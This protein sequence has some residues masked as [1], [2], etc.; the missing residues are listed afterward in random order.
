M[1][2]TS[3]VVGLAGTAVMTALVMGA[4]ARSAVPPNEAARLKSDLTPLGAERAGNQAG[5][6]PAWEGGYTKVWPGYQSGQPRPDPFAAEK[7]LV[8]ISAQNLS[9]H[10][11]R[12]SDG[13]K[14]LLKR[15][16][17][18]R[19]DVYPTHRTAAA[20]DWVYENTFKNATSARTE[21]DGLGI[22]GAYGGVPF[23]I[24]KTGAEVMWNH[25]LMW[26]GEARTYEGSDYVVAARKPVLSSTTLVE[27]QAQ[28]YDSRGKPDNYD[29]MNFKVIVTTVAPPFRA[30][31]VILV[32]EP[33]DIYRDGRRAWQYLPGQRRVRRTPTISY[34][35]PSVST[36]GFTFYDEAVMFNGPLDR[37]T[38]KLLGKREIY[39]PY[40]TNR[41]Q[42]TKL[43][44]VLGPDHLNPDAL[45]WELHRVWVVEA[46]IAPGK[47]HVL[48]KRRFYVDEDSWLVMLYDGW[49]ARGALWH[50]G[51]MLPIIAP[52]FP[53]VVVAPQV[54]YDLV[55]GGYAAAS[56]FNERGRQYQKQERRPEEVFTPAALSSSGI[57]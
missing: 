55:K 14:A 23:P 48:P 7:P 46:T 41:F 49:D 40:N 20:P 39:I 52:E 45:R 8:S 13:V 19:L 57:R 34:D 2:R 5:T 50:V 16:P 3:V 6:I 9:S 11:A 10:E 47:R 24:P 12:L 35:N 44:D 51:H 22:S 56:L 43:G 31:E 53:A 36:S 30:G 28:Y 29:D 33:V 42:S 18:Y 17:S 27:V 25:F 26:R 21:D 37:Y 38:W 1:A 32:H 15:F 4:V 54:I